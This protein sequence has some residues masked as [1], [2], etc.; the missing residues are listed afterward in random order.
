M[1]QDKPTYEEIQAIADKSVQM[2]TSHWDARDN[3]AKTLISVASGIIALTVTFA[4]TIVVPQSIP[5]WRYL[6][7]ASWILFL[8]S[9]V[10]G[11]IVLWL[12]K[13]IR[14]FSFKFF[15]NRTDIKSALAGIDQTNPESLKPMHNVR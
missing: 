13:N 3:F 6:L 12:T 8:V 5:L 7:F 15:E 14:L 1:S 10:C 9:I 11:G 2:L 4:K